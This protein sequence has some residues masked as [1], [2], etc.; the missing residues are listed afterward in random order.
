METH[1]FPVIGDYCLRQRAADKQM[2]FG[3]FPEGG[4]QALVDDEGLRSAVLQECDLLVVPFS[5][6]EVH[7]TPD[8]FNFTEM[9]AYHQFI[10]EHGLQFQGGSLIWHNIL[11]QWLRDKLDDPQGTTE[12]MQAIVS[13]YIATT[14]GRY[15]GSAH[16]WVVV[17]EAIEPEDG[18]EDGLRQSPWL[19]R[20]G[21]DYIAFA[22]RAA[23]ATDPNLQLI[24][25]DYGLEYDTAT[26]EARRH[27]TLRL[28]ERL[29]SQGVPIHAL[30][31][32]SHLSGDRTGFNGLR[33]FLTSVA[34]LG[35]KIF[36]S[37]LDVTD[38]GLSAEIDRRDR[39]VAQVYEDFLSVVLESPAVVSVITWGLSDRYTWLSYHAPRSDGLP[40]RP[41][42][43]DHTMN[44]KPAW[45]A[46][47]RAIDHSPLRLTT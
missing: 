18:R 43:L 2:S 41:L 26:D 19:N 5:W 17:N 36:V 47:A 27:A 24:Y 37:E 7:P 29:V 30:G 23:A 8:G 44:R 22:F 21:E 11:P 28:L 13:H 38:S 6:E 20:L 10:L 31:L 16:S 1:D 12:D 14:V 3:T 4:Y 9:D 40:V 45:N 39:Q 25:N 32:Q 15:A 46:I 35:L 42:P 34:D 33:D